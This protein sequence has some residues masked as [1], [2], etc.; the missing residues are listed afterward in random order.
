MQ[1]KIILED[2]NGEQTLIDSL[3]VHEKAVNLVKEATIYD[4]IDGYCLLDISDESGIDV[5]VPRAE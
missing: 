5:I 1:L 2:D 4:I 3:E